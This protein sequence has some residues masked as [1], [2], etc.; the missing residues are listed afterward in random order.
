MQTQTRHEWARILINPSCPFDYKN[1]TKNKKKKNK[2]CLHFIILGD[3]KIIISSSA[4]VH[5]I[6]PKYTVKPGAHD[7]LSV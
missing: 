5:A 1:W 6:L 4:N 2:I 7:T 3:S